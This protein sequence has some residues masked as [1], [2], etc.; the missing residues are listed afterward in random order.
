MQD[1]CTT[2]CTISP[3]R[4]STLWMP[5]LTQMEER[6]NVKKVMPSDSGGVNGPESL[7]IRTAGL[8]QSMWSL[9]QWVAPGSQRADTGGSSWRLLPI[10][11]SASTQPF[12]P[13]G[14]VP[15]KLEDWKM[16]HRMTANTIISWMGPR[17]P[18]PFN[19][20]S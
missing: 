2:H 1:Q 11:V 12:L 17:L 5:N 13:S 14:Q 3:A 20:G 10:A 6:D 16:C 8:P 18:Q 4:Q 15:F 19:D 7:P 9:I